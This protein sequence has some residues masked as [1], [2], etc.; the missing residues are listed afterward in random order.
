MQP[1]FW[2]DEGTPSPVARLALA[3]V[4]GRAARWLQQLGISGALPSICLRRS[5][6]ARSSSVKP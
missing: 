3:N 1:A 5:M 4:G 6:S 2:Y